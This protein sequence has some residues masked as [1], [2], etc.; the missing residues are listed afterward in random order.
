MAKPVLGPACILCTTLQTHPGP[1]MNTVFSLCTIS[2][3]ENPVFINWE[4]CNENRFFPSV[5]ILHKENPVLAL[6]WP[7]SAVH[8]FK[9]D[10]WEIHVGVDF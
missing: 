2:N 4:P 6:Y 9:S 1:V 8:G 5:E 3:R 10:M 7:C